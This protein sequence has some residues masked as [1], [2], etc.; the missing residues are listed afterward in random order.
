[1][2]RQRYIVAERMHIG[3]LADDRD[4]AMDKATAIWT[5]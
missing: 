3:G 4:Q 1:V 5:S 2:Y